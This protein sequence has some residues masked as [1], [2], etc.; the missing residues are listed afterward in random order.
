MKSG[1][2][3]RET[4]TARAARRAANRLCVVGAAFAAVLGAGVGLAPGV[5][6]ADGVQS[7]QWYLDDMRSEQ[8]WKVSTGKG[9]KVAVIDSG[10]NAKTASLK[11]QVLGDEVT[12]DVGY[13]A[14][15]DYAG[16]GTTIAEMIAGTGAGGGIQGIAPGA[17]IVPYRILLDELKDKAERKLTPPDYKAVRAAADSDAKIINMSFGSEYSDPELR[18]AVKY[19]YSKGK[20]LFAAAGNEAKKKNPVEYPAAYPGV[21]GVASLDESGQ[22]GEFSQHGDYIDLSAPGL[23]LPYWCDTTFRSYCNSGAGTSFSSAYAS[24]AAALIWS[25]HPDWTANQVL[26]VLIDTAARD[27]P[28]NTPSNYLGYGV[29]RPS[30]NLLDGKGKPGA[31]DV[32]PITNEKTEAVG[33]N[34]D[35]TPSASASA[36]SQAP[37]DS[38]DGDT[39]AAGSEAESSSDSSTLWIVLG[40]VAAVIVLGGGG[41]A[42]LRARRN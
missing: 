8:M 40:V 31:A 19:A 6:A 38:S 11:G 32:D 34:S 22:V 1:T 33:S 17:K 37:K 27:W 28:K 35:T 4:S 20:L 30:Q 10:V 41:M 9:V 23:D 18:A 2:S 36:S 12:G 39:S 29:V 26:R 25:A 14:T 16:H 15:Q 24:A 21:V 3:C 5:A 42:V 7:R 13:H